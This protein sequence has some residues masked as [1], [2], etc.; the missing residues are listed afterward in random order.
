VRLACIRHAASVDPEPGS[1]SPPSVPVP[2]DPPP[3]KG[4]RP[5]PAGTPP[6][7]WCLLSDVDRRPTPARPPRP[8]LPRTARASPRW[9]AIAALLFRL[10]HPT[11]PQVRPRHGSPPAPGFPPAPVPVPARAPHRVVRRSTCQGG[12]PAVGQEDRPVLLQGG[13]RLP[14]FRGCS[15]VLYETSRYMRPPGPTRFR[16]RLAGSHRQDPKCTQVSSLRQGFRR[17]EIRALHQVVRPSLRPVSSEASA[18]I[19]TRQPGFKGKSGAILDES[20]NTLPPVRTDHGQGAMAAPQLAMSR[21]NPPRPCRAGSGSG[22]L[23]RC[24]PGCTRPPRCRRHRSRC[25]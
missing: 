10:R 23:R 19:Q 21:V 9:F 20:W 16:V 7:P 24:F 4:C 14:R 22:R 5:W 17:I 18:M 15:N 11:S 1:N 3:P 6:R 2:Q 12:L 8:G 13:D 25:G